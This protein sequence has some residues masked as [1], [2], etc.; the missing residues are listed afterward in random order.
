MGMLAN[1][2][3]QTITPSY[4]NIQFYRTEKKFNHNFK[5]SIKNKICFLNTNK[6]F[7]GPN[8][9]KIIS[10]VNCQEINSMTVY[11]HLEELKERFL[12]VT[13]SFIISFICILS[14]SK[15]LLVAFELNGLKNNFSFLQLTPGEFF[16]T[17]LEVATYFGIACGLPTL[18]Y[19]IISYILP[20][21]TKNEKEFYLPLLL[22]S[23]FLFIL[24]IIFSFYF[25]SPFA[26]SFF[27]NYSSGSVES[28]LSIKQYFDFFINILL[29]SGIAFQIPIIQII[30]GKTRIISSEQ[31]LRLWKWVVIGS[32]IFSAI[33]TPTTDPVTQI[34][35][36]AP[37]ITLYFLGIQV[38]KYFE[39]N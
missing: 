7:L 8:K 17:S 39:K 14:I 16:F 36:C 30:L 6:I 32:T 12:L 18:I 27:V 24:G 37:I 15:D 13:L 31:M 3:K 38:T 11:D 19:Q 2:I 29:S 9:R 20:G 33:I 1:N 21:L 4:S 25:I 5:D 10:R 35:T 23:S 26:L 22:G 34:L 28:T